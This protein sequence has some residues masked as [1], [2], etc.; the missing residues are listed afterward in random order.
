MTQFVM[1]AVAK[2]NRPFSVINVYGRWLL[3][4][5]AAH[6]DLFNAVVAAMHRARSGP[7]GNVLQPDVIMHKT[8]A[9]S[10]LRKRLSNGAEDD[11][12]ILTVL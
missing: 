12:A 10:L 4:E 6:A 9:L 8:K 1:P 7:A 11:G 3:E 5:M 2:S